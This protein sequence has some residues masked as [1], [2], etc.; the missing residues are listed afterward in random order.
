MVTEE[1][2]YYDNAE[3]FVSLDP[4][5]VEVE[6]VYGLDFWLFSDS[7]WKSLMGIYR[8]LPGWQ[9][10]AEGVPFWFGVDEDNPP[11][12]AA[13]VEPSGLMVHGVL[14]LEDWEGWDSKFRGLVV[15][16]PRRPVA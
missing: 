11:Y 15:S 9:N 2:W 4:D 16:L 3:D 6:R 10:P 5:L 7:D 8:Q 12:L 14:P 13:S 1:D